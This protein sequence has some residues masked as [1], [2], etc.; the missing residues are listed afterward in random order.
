MARVCRVAHASI[1]ARVRCGARRCVGAVALLVVSEFR[2][3]DAWRRTTVV[4]RA[5][6]ALALMGPVVGCYAISGK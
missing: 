4:W 1:V 3:G 6:L 5:S 2:V